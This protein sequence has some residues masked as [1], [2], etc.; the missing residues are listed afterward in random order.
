MSGT[1]FAIL[2][3]GRMGRALGRLLAQQGLKPT[4]VTAQTLRSARQAAAF[5]GG[6][7][8]GRSNLKAVAGASLVFITTPDRVI[9]L[10]ADELAESNL[11][12]GRRVV[13]HTSGALSSSVLEPLRRRGAQVASIHPLASIAD[14]RGGLR[15][16]AGIPFAIEGDPR[17]VRRLRR[18]VVSFRGMPV[19]IPREAKALYHLIAVLMSNDLVALLSI[20]L[21]TA[22]SIGLS[23]RQ[24]LRLYMPLVRGTV[25]N[26]DRLGVV[27]ALTG[28]VSRGDA[29]TLRLHAEV[30]RTL[31]AEFRKLHRFLGVQS[32]DL[33]LRARTITPEIATRLIRLLKAL[34]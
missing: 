12:W 26:V 17:A 20:G 27:K 9:P 24:A 8:P 19:T 29:N 31:P 10:L 18:L 5:I 7:E 2:G 33:A 1:A 15:D 32:A 13:A 3:A 34:P 4:G 11:R 22:R 16:P 28:P 30:L 21:E 23:E 14:P 25:D 6:G